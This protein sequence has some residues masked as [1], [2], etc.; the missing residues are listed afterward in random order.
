MTAA[1]GAPTVRL[2]RISLGGLQLGDLPAGGF[3]ELTAEER[4]LSLLSE[5]PL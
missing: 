4:Q 3:R 1:A 5:L 2:K